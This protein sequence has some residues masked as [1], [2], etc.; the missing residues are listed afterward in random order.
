[1]GEYKQFVE[2]LAIEARWEEALPYLNRSVT[3]AMADIIDGLSHPNWVIRKWCVALLD[4]HADAETVAFLANALNDR[5]SDVRRLAVHAIGCD[6]CKTK[7]LQ[8]DVVGLLLERVRDDRSLKVRRAA[9]NMLAV[10]QADARAVP[11]LRSILE[12]EDDQRLCEKVR[13]A[14]RQHSAP[15]GA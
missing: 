2:K 14:L 4:H 5:H 3:E 13:R 6:A 11:A 10:Q 9:A 15:D 8:I 1:M 12:Q 7:A